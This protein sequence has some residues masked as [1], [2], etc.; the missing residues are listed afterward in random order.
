MGSFEMVHAK[1][2]IFDAGNMQKSI[3]ETH[4]TT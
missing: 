2:I 4:T 1:Y 3:K